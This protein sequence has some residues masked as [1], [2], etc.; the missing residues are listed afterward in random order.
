MSLPPSDLWKKVVPFFLQ[1]TCLIPTIC[2]FFLINEPQPFIC[3][4]PKQDGLACSRPFFHQNG[5]CMQQWHYQTLFLHV[6]CSRSFIACRPQ[7][8]ISSFY[9]FFFL[10]VLNPQH[11]TPT[12]TNEKGQNSRQQAVHTSIP[13]EKA[14]LL[15]FLS[16]ENPKKRKT[17]LISIF[18][19]S[20]G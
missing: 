5:F 14:L 2:L 10:T 4:K 15:Q 12:G 8:Q 19:S 16:V 17:I 6:G 18:I 7:L 11:T 9:V 20:F 1:K 3:F 13:Q